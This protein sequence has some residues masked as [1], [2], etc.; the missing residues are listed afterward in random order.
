MAHFSARLA[1]AATAVFL[2][3]AAPAAAVEFPFDLGLGGG[4]DRAQAQA[5]PAQQPPVLMA[6]AGD[7]GVR[8][9]Q[10]EEEI[11][12]LTGRVEE[13]SF[14]VLQLQEQLRNAQED[15]ELRFQDLEGGSG[16]GGGQTPERRSEAT[17][18]AAGGSGDGEFALG[19]PPQ[20]TSAGGNAASGQGDDVGAL[21]DQASLENL[22]GSIG[23]PGSQGGASGGSQTVA[24]INA[25]GPVELYSLAYNYMLAGDYQLAEQ[26]FRQYADTYPDSE[27]AS[28]ARYWLGES[29]F[30]QNRFRDAAEVFLNA[31][32]AHPDSGKAPE[33]ML[34]LGM[35]LARLD[36]RDTACVTYAEVERR[37]PQMS[38]NVRRKLGEEERTASCT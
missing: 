32:K 38:D 2:I 27:D 15:N 22:G 18:P 19:L 25:N 33:M 8:L 29:L 9:S 30:A 11:R 24:S 7:A 34:K 3:G 37:Y 28:D 13:M 21:L 14:L 5:A 6:Q 12:R 36:N 16:G 31:Q 35:S 20:G 10:M 1:G 23:Q 26:S 4:N 17:P